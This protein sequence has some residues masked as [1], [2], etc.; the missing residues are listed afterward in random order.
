M[1]APYP[2]VTTVQVTKDGKAGVFGMLPNMV[3]WSLQSTEYCSAVWV[4][5]ALFRV[6]DVA[7]VF[8]PQSSRRRVAAGGTAA[9]P[10]PPPIRLPPQDMSGTWSK[11]RPVL[12]LAHYNAG[13]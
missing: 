9:L 10:P 13:F 3:L 8:Q 2:A 6:D 1:F 7:Q 5:S 12:A 11:V 4:L